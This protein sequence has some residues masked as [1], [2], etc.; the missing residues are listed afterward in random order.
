MQPHLLTLYAGTWAGGGLLSPKIIGFIIQHSLEIKA[1]YDNST[2][3]N[4][5]HQFQ[6]EFNFQIKTQVSSHCAKTYNVLKLY[7]HI[8]LVQERFAR[9]IEN[10]L[11]WMVTK[12]SGR[13]VIKRIQHFN[14]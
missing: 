6:P 13:L 5:K 10:G 4:S 3:N 2:M 1:K 12:I 8:G 14:I 7:E 11:V 9:K